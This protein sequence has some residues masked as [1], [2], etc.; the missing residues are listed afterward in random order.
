MYQYVVDEVAKFADKLAALDT[1]LQDVQQNQVSEVQ[2]QDLATGGQ[3]QAV[4]ERVTQLETA[5]RSFV[6]WTVTVVRMNLHTE[7]N[8]KVVMLKAKL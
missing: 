3:V 5:H 8:G 4:D 2:L 6:D 1:N 7:F